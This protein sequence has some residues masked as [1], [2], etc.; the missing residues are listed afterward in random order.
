MLKDCP[1]DMYER[2]AA[3][4]FDAALSALEA[5]G[6]AL[7]PVEPTARMLRCGVREFAGAERYARDYEYCDANFTE[8]ARAAWTAMLTASRHKEKNDG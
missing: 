8:K 6:I 4:L 5:A 1:G 2:E 3:E 7:V